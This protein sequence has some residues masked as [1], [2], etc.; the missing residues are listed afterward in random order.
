MFRH[1]V[2]IEFLTFCAFYIILQ[3]LLQFINIE[4]RRSGSATL[5]A[6]SGLFA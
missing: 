1:S 6:V 4:S 5:A 2:V 3:A